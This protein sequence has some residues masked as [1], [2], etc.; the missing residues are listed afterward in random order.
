[1]VP[2]EIGGHFDPEDWHRQLRDLE[3][4]ASFMPELFGDDSAAALAGSG[5]DRA[6]EGSL[7]SLSKKLSAM[8]VW[9]ERK[10]LLLQAAAVRLAM[11]LQQ[12]RRD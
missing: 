2:E 1:M 6:A 11:H 7:G 12:A 9:H 10:A 5:M 3:A 8:A 4:F